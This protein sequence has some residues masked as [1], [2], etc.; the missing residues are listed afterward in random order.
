MVSLAECGVNHS[1]LNEFFGTN[2]TVNYYVLK[3]SC[4]KEPQPRS[5]STSLE[6]A[7]RRL[8]SFK[9]NAQELL[10]RNV[11]VPF[12][13]GIPIAFSPYIRILDE[14]VPGTSQ[15]LLGEASPSVQHVGISYMMGRIRGKDL[16][17]QEVVA[18]NA[19]REETMKIYAFLHDCFIPKSIREG[20]DSQVS[21]QMVIK[22]IIG[23][24]SSSLGYVTAQHFF[25]GRGLEDIAQQFKVHRQQIGQ[26]VDEAK[27]RLATSF[28]GGLDAILSSHLDA[29]HALVKQSDEGRRLKAIF[30]KNSFPPDVEWGG[31]LSMRT[32]TKG[33]SPKQVVNLEELRANY[34]PLE[35]FWEGAFTSR[36]MP[37]LN[38]GKGINVGKLAAIAKDI[39]IT[40]TGRRSPEMWARSVISRIPGIIE[41]A[42]KGDPNV[43]KPTSYFCLSKFLEPGGEPIRTVLYGTLEKVISSQN[44]GFSTRSVHTSAGA[45]ITF[46]QKG[47]IFTKADLEGLLSKGE[48]EVRKL[49]GLY[50]PDSHSTARYDH[51]IA[52]CRALDY[53]PHP[54]KLAMVPMG[55]PMAATA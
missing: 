34:V 26:L 27:E 41:V 9:P 33:Y 39:G 45:V 15:T 40:S 50:S 4:G 32:A 55:K 6:N 17:P 46:L 10:E 43:N 44:P 2:T 18:I 51:F 28:E 11:L 23:G 19:A 13:E 31:E 54:Q 1:V 24:Q 38:E 8:H 49:T 37:D 20:I 3:L 12:F 22:K 16:F 35:Q 14:L 42:Y 29:M 21:G 7:I 25:A 52:A 48:E 53:L 47:G 5:K 36:L 30:L